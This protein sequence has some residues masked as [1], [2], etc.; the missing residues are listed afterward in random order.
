MIH[1]DLIGHSVVNPVL[2]VK[3]GPVIEYH[4]G[5]NVNTTLRM[6]S[7]FDS[8]RGKRKKLLSKRGGRSGRKSKIS[9]P[10]Q[11]PE[12]GCNLSFALLRQYKIHALEHTNTFPCSLD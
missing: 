6:S 4:I 12:E 8:K 11:C 5:Q 1:S 10:V 3:E 2:E 7:N 9:L